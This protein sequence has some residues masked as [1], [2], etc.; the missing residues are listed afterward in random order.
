MI[1]I[2]Y[3]LTEKHFDLIVKKIAGLLKIDS[4]DKSFQLRFP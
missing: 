4:Y 3:I 1:Y 2:V